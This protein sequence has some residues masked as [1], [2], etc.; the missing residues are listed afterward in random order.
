VPS[1]EAFDNAGVSAVGSGTASLLGGHVIPNFAGYLPDL[2][3]GLQLTDRNGNNVT[4]HIRNEE[5]FVGKAR[6][7]RS[8]QILENGVA[9]VIDQV[10]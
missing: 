10:E 1:N 7:I 8:N 9:H 2:T 4:I 6:I 5:Y 3:D